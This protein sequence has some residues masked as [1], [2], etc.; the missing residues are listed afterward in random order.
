[1]S[2]R[3]FRLRYYLRL[4]VFDRPGVLGRVATELGQRNVS[5]AE[6]V[7]EPRDEGRADVVIVTHLAEEGAVKDALAALEREGLFASSP[8]LVR[9]EET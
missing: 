4:S 7:Q 9:I 3:E 6:L 5:L 8:A 2:G 1:M